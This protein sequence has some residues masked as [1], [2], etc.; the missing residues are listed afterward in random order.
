[1]TLLPWE[2]QFDSSENH[3]VPMEARASMGCQGSQN[4]T[5][6]LCKKKKKKQDA[7]STAGVFCLGKRPANKLLPTSDHTGD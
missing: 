7:W 6:K 3:T 4:I 1:M 2:A 5:K